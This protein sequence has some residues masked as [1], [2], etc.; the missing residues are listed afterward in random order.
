MSRLLR[1]EQFRWHGQAYATCIIQLTEGRY[2]AKTRLGIKDCI[3]TDADSENEA[4]KK[5]WQTLPTAL[6]ARGCSL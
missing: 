3:I 4:L 6:L 1:I 5:H 2:M